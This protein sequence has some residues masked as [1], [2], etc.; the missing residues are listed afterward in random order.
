M[1]FPA[2]AFTKLLVCV[3][4]QI[5]WVA[6]GEDEGNSI[7]V[8]NGLTRFGLNKIVSTIVQALIPGVKC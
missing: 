8:G 7:W 6:I 2:N 5:D 1:K 3:W 4:V